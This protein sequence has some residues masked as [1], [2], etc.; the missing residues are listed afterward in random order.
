[1]VVVDILGDLKIT[2]DLPDISMS[3]ESLAFIFNNTFGFDT[4][5]VN[6]CFEEEASSGFSKMT[7][8]FAIENLNNLGFY[9]KPSII[10]NYKIIVLF[11]SR[12]YA[13]TKKIN[14]DRT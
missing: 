12:L 1:M 11:F 2:D 14:L 6:G 13:L 9:V 7:K 4:L 8:I 3:S 10:F 5:T